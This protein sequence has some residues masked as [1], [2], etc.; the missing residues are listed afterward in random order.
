MA[1]FAGGNFIL[2]GTLLDEKKYIDFGLNLTLSYY[3]TYRSTASGIGPEAFSWGDGASVGGSPPDSQVDFY[4]TAGF[5]TTFPAYILRPET[6]ESLYY[7]YRSTGDTNYQD[8]AWE[9]FNHI[10]KACGTPDGFSG[11][12]DV[13]RQ[14]GGGYDDSQQSFWLA[15]T[16]KYLYLIFDTD[17][18]V[19]VGAGT[20]DAFVFNTEA[21]PLRVRH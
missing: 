11:I 18:P 4:N 7:A 15:E 19:H 1:S 21:H 5:W 17:S 20:G 10:Q 9:A 2:G 12:R 16:L 14:N 13:T 8:L 3:E 6:V